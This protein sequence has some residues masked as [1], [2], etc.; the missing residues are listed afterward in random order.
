MAN[1]RLPYHLANVHCPP[2]LTNGVG[3]GLPSL[4]VHT[5]VAGDRP[6]G[7]LS[8]HRPPVWTHQHTCHHT[9]GAIPWWCRQTDRHTD[10]QT[11]ALDDQADR[12]SH[13]QPLHTA[14]PPHISAPPTLRNCIRLHVSI[15]V[16]ARPH[17]ASLAL[18]GLSHHVVDETVLVPDTSGIKLGLVVPGGR[19]GRGGEGYRHTFASACRQTHLSYIS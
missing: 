1:R 13:A 19:E 8:L 16:L 5:V 7:C 9:Q 2:A 17:E 12:D 10:I 14:P 11:G 15:I 4:L 6:M 3:G 18:H